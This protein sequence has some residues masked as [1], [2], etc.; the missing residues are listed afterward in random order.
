MKK[1]W[2]FLLCLFLSLALSV[3]IFGVYAETTYSLTFDEEELKRAVSAESPRFFAYEFSD[4][5]AREGERIEV[6]GEVYAQKS[7]VYT[8]YEELPEDLVRAFVAIEDKYGTSAH[9]YGELLEAYGITA[10]HIQEKAEEIYK[11]L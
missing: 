8:T 3:V 2:I 10:A 6:T 4:R 11:I 1:G 5:S 9:E 7:R